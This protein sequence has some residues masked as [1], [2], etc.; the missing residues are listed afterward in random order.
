MAMSEN[1][2]KV[3]EFLKENAGKDYTSADVAEALG[4]SRATVDGVFT[5]LQKKGLGVRKDATIDG[6]A[7]VSFLA[8][9]EAGEAFDASELSEN[10]Q[11]ILSY[12]KDAKGTNLTLDDLSEAI[13]VEKKKVNGAFNAL[14]RKELCVRNTATIKAPVSVKYLVLTD[15]GM[16]F[17]PDAQD[18]E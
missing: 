16:S 9:T 15:E 2:V 10:A 17:D 18:A 5:A 4:L 1:S 13:D 14:V 7:E 6:T 3:M 8:I 11:K 12:L